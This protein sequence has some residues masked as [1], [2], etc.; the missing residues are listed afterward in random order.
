MLGYVYMLDMSWG[1]GI[2]MMLGWLALLA[3]FLSVVLAAVRD[4][5]APSPREVLDRRLAAGEINGPR[6]SVHQHRL[7]P[8]LG[9]SRRARVGRVGR[10]CL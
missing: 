5:R 4:R 8:D 3:I 2:L 10:R 6:Q 1:W 9:R 7:Q